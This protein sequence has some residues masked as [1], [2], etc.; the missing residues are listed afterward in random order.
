M[1]DP[2]VILWLVV[3]IAVILVLIIKFKMNAAI[4]MFIGALVLGIACNLGMAGT[5]STISSGFG[6]TMTS[7][8]LSVGFGVMLGQLVADVGAVQTLANGLL[9]LFGEKKAD[10]A[11]GSTGFIVSIPVFYDVGYVILMPLAKTLA[12]KS[13]QKILPHFIGGLVAGLGI[14]HTFIPPTPGPMTGGELM[15]VPIG[16][17]I[18]VGIAIGLPTFLISMFIYN[19]FF[20]G[21]KG[22]WNPETD[23]EHDPALE[24]EAA[25][26]AKELTRDE[27]KLPGMFASVLPI[28]LPIVLILITTVWDAIVGDDVNGNPLTPDFIRMIGTKEF[29]MMAGTIAAMVV[30][31]MKHRMTLK[32]VEKSVNVAVGAAG[33]VLLI[34]GMGGGLGAVITAT[35]VGDILKDMLATINMP[36]ILFVWI[37][38]AL[39]KIAQGSGTVAMVTGL[40]IVASMGDLGVSPVLIAMAGFSGSLCGAHVNDSAF[41]VT[42]KIS[43]LT[44]VG[45][46]K[47]YTLVCFIQ[48]IISLIIISVASLFFH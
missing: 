19:K 10:Y 45:G 28:A 22:F 6:S 9:K 47:T 48:S 18:A 31:L 38:A 46:F 26:R 20:L 41:W 36:V 32:Q 44:T 3:A 25:A 29:A 34:T 8:G 11:M 35:G 16:V 21:R 43:G 27:S 12:K 33:T 4:A 7:I 1:G 17:T 37:I 2:M 30:C 40:T 5:V 24:A 15:G 39:L 13:T 23:E 14:A 42:T